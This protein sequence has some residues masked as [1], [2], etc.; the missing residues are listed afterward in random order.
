M[1]AE[2]KQRK[3]L[4][5]LL[6]SRLSSAESIL[7]KLCARLLHS[8]VFLAALGLPVL[9]MIS[10]FGGVPPELIFLTFTSSV[11]TV[12]LVACVSILIST[13][14]RRPREA[15]SLVYVQEFSWLFLPWMVRWIMPTGGGIWLLIYEWIRPVVDWTYASSP[16]SL[17]RSVG[18]VGGSGALTDFA[19]MVGLQLG[20]GALCL[21]VA[22]VRL[23]P[24]YRKQG[25]TSRWVAALG[26][27]RRGKR[28]LPRP[29]CG[30]DGMLWKERY[31]SRT[32]A[33]TKVVAGL[34]VLI[35]G[36]L[37]TYSAVDFAKP[38]LLEVVEYGYGSTTQNSARQSF[39]H[40]LRILSGVVYVVWALAIASASS[41]SVAHE[42]EEDTWTSLMATPLEG[43][44]ILRAKMLGAVWGTRW[45]GA[46]LL[47]LWT[48][49]L[50]TG[51]LHLLGYVAAIVE[52]VVFIWFATALGTS[53]SLWSK[54]SGRALTAT[55][56]IMLVLNGG[57]TLCCIPLQPDTTLIVLGITP[58]VLGIS[59]MSYENV[60]FTSRHRVLLG[61]SIMPE[62]VPR[63]ASSALLATASRPSC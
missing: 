53:V 44:N 18:L 24:V 51:S 10:L 52:S 61:P 4:H 40:Y 20:V 56:G 33:F 11:T 25:D 2:E 34:I 62:A 57:Y 43:F 30:D 27:L 26:S 54:H 16:M 48:V 58:A 36:G 46:L 42:R 14:A 55:L 49:G 31:V 5:Y 7:G 1:I 29:D 37:I 28:L 8:G 59:L 13:Y 38:A 32:S 47:V 21:F 41:G 12:F 9:S 15:I 45:L 6:A 3:T 17:I 23:R 19:W 22:V 35:V 60:L 63:L 50:A 39:S